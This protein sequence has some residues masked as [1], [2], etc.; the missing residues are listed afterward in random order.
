[1]FLKS[2]LKCFIWIF[3][4]GYSVLE[5]ILPAKPGDTFTKEWPFGGTKIWVPSNF[6]FCAGGYRV[7]I[8]S[9]KFLIFLENFHWGIESGQWSYGIVLIYVKLHELKTFGLS[10]VIKKFQRFLGYW[11][12][13]RLLV[14]MLKPLKFQYF[15]VSRNCLSVWLSVA[16]LISCV[17]MALTLELP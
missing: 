12:D 15:H 7:N 4:T 17:F 8:F 1:M 9:S 13:Y 2:I 3:M 14:Q 10:Y 5:Q 16:T 11:I 6:P